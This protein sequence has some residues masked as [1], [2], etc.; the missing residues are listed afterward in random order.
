MKLEAQRHLGYASGYLDLK[1]YE[2]A[3]READATLACE[4]DE[5]HAIAMKST[6]L[7]EANRLQEAEPLV[8]KLAEINPKESGIWINLAYIRRRT[9]SLDA[10]VAT[11]Q[12]AFDANPRDALAHFN[13]ACYRA[14][15]NRPTEAL[16]LLKNALHLDPKLRSLARAERDLDSLR[17]LPEFRSLVQ[18]KRPSR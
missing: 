7:W 2:D 9:Q 3:L 12:R 16:A 14:M 1:M 10:A 6:I 18:N 8:A 11:L 15:Q 4:P 13:M 17:E 5:P